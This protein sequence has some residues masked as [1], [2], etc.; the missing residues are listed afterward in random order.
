VIK[1]IGEN[2]EGGGVFYNFRVESDELA[3]ITGWSQNYILGVPETND[4]WKAGLPEYTLEFKSPGFVPQ[5][6]TFYSYVE[7]DERKD[8]TVFG[9]VI[10][11]HNFPYIADSTYYCSLEETLWSQNHCTTQHQHFYVFEGN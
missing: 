8:T 10:K 2:F 6:E 1:S 3:E 11:K 4:S 9:Y 5:K 7:L